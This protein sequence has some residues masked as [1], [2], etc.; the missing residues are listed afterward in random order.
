MKFQLHFYLYIIGNKQN[1][2][3]SASKIKDAIISVDK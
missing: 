3:K 1:L 2:Q